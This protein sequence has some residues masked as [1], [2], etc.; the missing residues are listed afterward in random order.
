M[1]RNNLQI[2]IH[3]VFTTKYRE[4]SI[5]RTL[6]KQLHL[7]LWLKATELEVIPLM[8]NGMDDHVHI[9]LKFSSLLTVAQVVKLLKGTSSRLMNELTN[10]QN[11]FQWSRG[12]GAFSVSPR[13]VSMIADYIKNQK[14]H[15]IKGTTRPELEDVSFS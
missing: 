11:Q 4:P 7:Y 14:E 5:N 9:L 3:F 15:Q 6:E 1:S 8:I 2:Y 12:Y 13:D 10:N